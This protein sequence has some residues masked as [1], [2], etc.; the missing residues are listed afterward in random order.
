M[1]NDTPKIT[2]KCMWNMSKCLLHALG[3]KTIRLF[4]VVCISGP[5]IILPPPY[6]PYQKSP[7]RYVNN[8]IYVYMGYMYMYNIICICIYE[9]IDIN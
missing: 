4:L 9:Y 8:V 5:I 1:I 7:I 3:V 2:L 6:Y